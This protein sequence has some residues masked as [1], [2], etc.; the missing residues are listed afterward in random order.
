ML[1]RRPFSKNTLGEFENVK[2]KIDFKS[3]SSHLKVSNSLKLNYLI[4]SPNLTSKFSPSIAISKSPSM[5][6]CKIEPISI[7]C[8]STNILNKYTKN[9]QDLIKNFPINF[10]DIEK[11]EDSNYSEKKSPIK[12]N[13]INLKNLDESSI[14]ISSPINILQNNSSKISNEQYNL[15]FIKELITF[16]MII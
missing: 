3:N 15:V 13:R 1:E 10:D 2:N 16:L 7:Y 6:N 14:N 12:R 5:K 4:A 8:E 9:T 11:T